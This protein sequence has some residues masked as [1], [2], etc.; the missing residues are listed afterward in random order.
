VPLR[1]VEGDPMIPGRNLPWCWIDTHTRDWSRIGV[2]R[3]TKD[4]CRQIR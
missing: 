1:E 2:E 3:G 4:V